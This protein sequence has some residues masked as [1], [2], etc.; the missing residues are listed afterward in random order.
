LV[1]SM[2]LRECLNKKCRCVY[3]MEG[4]DSCPLCKR[5]SKEDLEV[6]LEDEKN[7]VLQECT[8]EECGVEK[9]DTNRWP[10]CPECNPTEGTTE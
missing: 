10:T 9:F 2:T 8:N 6:Y 3:N 7:C 5:N 4:R 1:L